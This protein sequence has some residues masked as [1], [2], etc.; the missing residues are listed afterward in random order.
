[1]TS[2]Q[3]SPSHNVLP[4]P[5]SHSFHLVLLCLVSFLSLGFLLLCPLFLFVSPSILLSPP[6]SLYNTE[7]M[8]SVVL[9]LELLCV[10]WC[11]TTLETLTCPLEPSLFPRV[12]CSAPPT[13]GVS[14]EQRGD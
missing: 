8:L 10:Q 4:S 14:G 6:S 12:D 1:M 11:N 7:D 2:L 5:P 3:L 9:L 13:G